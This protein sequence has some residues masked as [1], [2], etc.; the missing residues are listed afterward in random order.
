MSEEKKADVL[1]VKERRKRLALLAVAAVLAAAGI[2]AVH[3]AMLAA[4]L[5]WGLPK[6]GNLAGVELR[7]GR[8]EAALG[9]P[10][11]FRDVVIL[12]A[13]ASPTRSGARLAEAVVSWSAPAGMFG[14]G[15]RL[16]S[17]AKLSGLEVVWERLPGP[18]PAAQSHATG[19]GHR[20]LPPLPY[21]FVAPRELEIK[22][23][24]LEAVSPEGWLWVEGVDALL[25]E[26]GEGFVMAASIQAG[27]GERSLRLPEQRAAALWQNGALFLSEAEIREG[28]R[29]EG[30]WVQAAPG[31]ASFEASADVFGGM[32][33]GGG[34]IGRWRGEAG[35]DAAFWAAG[36]N[37]ADLA[38]FL[39][40]EGE[41]SGRIE[42]ARLT[43]RGH[44][45]KWQAAEASLRLD[46]RDMRRNRRAWDRLE[47]SATLLNRRLT[48]PELELEQGA[49]RLSLNGDVAISGGW[50]EMASSPMRLN[51]SAKIEDLSALGL[52][53]GAGSHNLKGRMTI[54]A[55]LAGR[56]PRPEGFISV[57]ASKLE[58]RGLRWDSARLEA[59]L[60]NGEAH[61]EL[62]E[63]SRGR[64]VVTGQGVAG[65]SPPHEYSG[66]LTARLSNFGD[67]LASPGANGGRLDLR[68]QG[69]GRL[70]AHSGAFQAG[71]DGLRTP[72]TQAGPSGR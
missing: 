40:I 15:A 45:A 18:P 60:R 51:L 4:L 25:R 41:T 36:I 22:G 35:L 26:G 5:R 13:G 52:L 10:W 53:A 39:G 63:L 67:L 21:P 66:Q 55:R 28:L 56:M 62:F 38:G 71:V 44:P 47:I 37:V 42:E 59:L 14:R 3:P 16:F 7:M 29:L 48:I 2:W 27:W 68:W 17:K 32:L 72:W 34:R 30:L 69:D 8:V 19:A 9:R 20:I 31:G 50:A 12:P 43:F 65:L 49:N 58:A 24:S 23:L 46:A 1:P 70:G 54:S 11:I 57:E 33:R 6:L 61:I 64:D